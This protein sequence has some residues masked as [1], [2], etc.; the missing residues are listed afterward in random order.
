M[1]NFFSSKGFKL[2]A[3]GGFGMPPYNGLKLDQQ[4]TSQHSRPDHDQNDNHKH[5]KI[6]DLSKV[7]CV[8]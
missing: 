1:G 6:Q 7:V 8:K 3:Y 4:H 2:A 5:L